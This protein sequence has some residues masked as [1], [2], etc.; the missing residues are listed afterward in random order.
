MT[1]QPQEPPPLDAGPEQPQEPPGPLRAGSYQ[2]TENGITLIKETRGKAP[3]DK[4]G[5]VTGEGAVTSTQ[6]QQLTNFAA[7]IRGDVRTDDGAE[8]RRAYEI[9]AG[10][11]G[12]TASFTVP[13]DRF[14]AMNWPAE[15]LGPSAIVRPGMGLRDHAAVAIQELSSLGGIPSRHV[16]AHTGWRELDGGWGYLTAS[17]AIMA[18]GLHD[19]VTVDLGP[20]LSGY[21]LP[22]AADE[23]KEAGLREAIRASLAIL[24]VAPD[25]VTVP[26]LAA[27]YRAPL[28]LLPDCSAWL[29]GLS[30]ALKTALCALAQQ[31]WGA[32]LDAYSLP[33]NWTSTANTLEMQAFTLAGVLFTVDDYSPD[34][35]TME[36]R[37]RAAT[38]DRLLRGIANHAGRGR[39]SSDSSMRPVKPPRAQV[40]TSAEDLPPAG[41][42][43]R[44]RVM[45]SEVAKGA[46]SLPLMTTA[47]G[48]G[49]AGLYALAMAGYVRWLAGQYEAQRDSLKPQLAQMRDI[50]R[51]EGHLRTAVNIASLYL[52]WGQFLVY[53][54]A[55][56]AITADERQ[57]YQNRAWKTLCDLGSEQ[58]RYQRDADPASTYLRALGALVTSGRAHLAAPGGSQPAEPDRWGWEFS[59]RGKDG[60]HGIWEPQGDRLGW[61][62]DDGVYLDPDVAYRAARKFAEDAGSPLGVSK[63]A[64]HQ[65]L[66]DKRLLVST[67]P[68]RIPVQRRLS[69][70]QRRVLHLGT[71]M[72]ERD[73]E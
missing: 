23:A 39:L 45:V 13:A 69:G 43:L 35:T 51:S 36:A 53:S 25:S 31:H 6:N 29:Y 32:G 47:Q 56:G 28:P 9:S 49:D 26:L 38:A 65:Q 30:G 67:D 44:A 27:V 61:V 3:R 63:Y 42:S 21:A 40:L 11:R 57:Q 37:K 7:Q 64:L 41:M 54:Q 50:A 1:E 4:D 24:E 10:L 68:G 19:D 52:G 66:R 71:G 18:D 34:V 73:T 17:G 58:A 46:V 33:G 55:V 8:V 60:D 20:A 16:Y 22:D 2:M 5:N 72:F 59:I 14:R 62:A 12:R 70:Q 15:H 48:A